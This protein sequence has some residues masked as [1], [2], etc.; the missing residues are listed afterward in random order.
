MADVRRAAAS[1]LASRSLAIAGMNWDGDRLCVF[2]NTQGDIAGE[3]D[4]VGATVEECEF[5]SRVL[6]DLLDEE[7]LVPVPTYTLE[8]ST[9]GTSDALTKE[10]EFVAFKG[11][12]VAVRTS[13]LFKKKDVFE[14]SLYDRTEDAVRLV[15]K[16]RI[17]RIP[18]DIVLDV[19]LDAAKEEPL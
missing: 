17:F 12:Q 13:E 6:G 10:R 3:I 2:V 18:R 4:A 15:I 5:A 11:F 19:K 14:G 7:D 16:G 9:P 8:V 1:V